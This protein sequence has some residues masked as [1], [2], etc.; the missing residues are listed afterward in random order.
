VDLLKGA[1][2]GSAGRTTEAVANLLPG[3]ESLPNAGDSAN[4]RA[5]QTSIAA[6]LASVARVFVPDGGVPRSLV[7]ER[8]SVSDSASEA[9]ITGSA[10]APAE[11]AAASSAPAA[12][13]EPA[14]VPGDRVTAT[15]SFYYCEVGP[16][17][18]HVGDGGNFCGAMRDGS[19]VLAT[20]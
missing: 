3:G 6:S 2:V 12:A 5:L 1:E 16:K 14:L 15:V 18:R 20:P 8:V 4:D 19:I 10:P 17:G 9:A 11:V 13:A 7:A